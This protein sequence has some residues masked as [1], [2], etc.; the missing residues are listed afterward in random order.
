VRK[1][2]LLPAGRSMAALSSTLLVLA[3]MTTSA[4]AIEIMAGSRITTNEA[5]RSQQAALSQE[6]STASSGSGDGSD[7][8]FN[9][10]E[11]CFMKRINRI[12]RK[13]GLNKLRWDR[14][15]GVAGRRH[16]YKLAR[17]GTIWHDDIGAKVTRWR[18][19][20][21]NTG[22]GSGCR[23][24]TRAFMHSSGHRAN[25]LG[26]W[27]H[28]G[29]GVVRRKGTTYVQQIFERRRNPGNVWHKP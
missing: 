13:H 20:G 7:W 29:V 10:R 17:A 24:L 25:Y 26:K 19:L 21:Q 22:M 12:R 6:F 4:G 16:A 3:L 9:L 2:R 5:Y 1:T 14:H 23:R 15:L 11:R 28:V 8:R 18:S 27:R